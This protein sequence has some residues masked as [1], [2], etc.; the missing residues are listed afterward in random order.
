MGRGWKGKTERGREEERKGEKEERSKG[1]EEKR[2]GKE[3]KEKVS[4]SLV[5]QSFIAHAVS[6]K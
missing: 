6:H 3:R 2:K 1:E 4:L 5:N